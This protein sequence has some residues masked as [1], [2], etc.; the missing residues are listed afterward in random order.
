M[1]PATGPSS[2]DASA[3]SAD[4][5]AQAVEQCL[6]AC[7]DYL[8]LIA[9]REL[10][11]EIQPKCAPSDLVQQTL[12]EAWQ[13]FA[14]FRGQSEVELR[15]WL[16]RILVN[17]IHDATRKYRDTAK[18]GVAREIPLHGDG[19]Q[20]LSLNNLPADDQSPSACAAA[21]EDLSLLKETLSELPPHYAEVIRLRNLEDLPFADI[22]RQL[23]LSADSAR[24]L[25][26]RAVRRLAKDLKRRNG[27]D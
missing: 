21:Q 20:E 12:A 16:K 27:S 17:N 19:S 10:P 9:N 8:Q 2:L 1:P 22:G 23:S 24:K 4:F 26:E 25:W 11:S 13:S 15:G 18:R 3:A 14:N 5:S 6:E 7:R